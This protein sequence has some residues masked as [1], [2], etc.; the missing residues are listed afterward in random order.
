MTATTRAVVLAAGAATRMRRPATGVALSPDQAAMADRG[1]KALVPV[2]RPFLDYVLS[3]LADAG[4]SDVCLV[5][6]PEHEPLRRRYEVEVQPTRLRLQFAVQPQPRGTAEAVL[7]A[8]PVVG[9]DPFVLVNAD[10]LYPV[11][12]LAA[13]A[14]LDGYGLIGYDRE[15]LLEAGDIGPDRIAQYA[16]LSVAPEGWLER[17]IEKPDPDTV[18]RLGPDAPVSMNSWRF[19]PKIFEACRRIEPSP[20]GELEL[21][22]AVMVAMTELGVRFRVVPWRGSV[23]DL[24]SRPD[25]ARVARRVAGLEVRL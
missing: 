11:G 3:N 8:E 6:G 14:A 20:R 7:A 12:A 17:I 9:R 21:Q 1:L 16:I 19:G 25:I 2:G 10:N 15:G 5:V 24:S 13:L 23:L 22:D 4:L 18:R